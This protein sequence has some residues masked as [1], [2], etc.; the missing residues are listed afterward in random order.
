MLVA[1]SSLRPVQ[2]I[3]VYRW[4]AYRTRRETL[5]ATL[6]RDPATTAS[7]SP[8]QLGRSLTVDRTG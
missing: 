1:L 4:A 3:R 6:L 5:T 8:R 7:S 2:G